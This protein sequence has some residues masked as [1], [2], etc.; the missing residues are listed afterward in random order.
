MS[1]FVYHIC[2]MQIDS[3]GCLSVI[4]LVKVNLPNA[5]FYIMTYLF[6]FFSIRF[7]LSS[8]SSALYLLTD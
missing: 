3:S 5:M 8:F 2:L 6:L 7:V 4:F 1:R